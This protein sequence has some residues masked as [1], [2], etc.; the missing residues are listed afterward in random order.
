[1]NEKNYVIFVLGYDLLQDKLKAQQ[2]NECDTVYEQCKQIAKYFMK[3]EEYKNNNIGL[4]EALQRYIDRVGM[5][6]TYE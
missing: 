2:F 6:I 5:V 3:S 1:M 4:Y